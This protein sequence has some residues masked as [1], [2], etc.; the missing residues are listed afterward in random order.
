[1]RSTYLVNIDFKSCGRHTFGVKL[2]GR[3]RKGD[4]VRF[5]D[6]TL[7][8]TGYEGTVIRWAPLHVYVTSGWVD[9]VDETLP[10]AA[11]N[12]H[13]AAL[14]AAVDAYMAAP[15]AVEETLKFILRVDRVCEPPASAPRGGCDECD[16]CGVGAPPR[17]VC[18]GACV[19]NVRQRTPTCAD[20][21]E[22]V[23]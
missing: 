14:R 6:D 5:D 10:P 7:N 4:R 3:A 15:F 20:E 19:P 9:G 12:G 1:M 16:E 13:E 18:S 2:P 8:L 23:G 17:R 11:W 21:R 22:C